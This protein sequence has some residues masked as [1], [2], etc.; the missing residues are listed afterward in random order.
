MK[1]EM[2]KGGDNAFEDNKEGWSKA[3]KKGRMGWFE[4]E[5]VG[6]D[7]FCF[8]LF[9]FVFD[10]F[11]FVLFCF[12]L[13]GF[14][15]NS[16]FLCF[17]FISFQLL[18]DSYI[19]ISYD[20]HDGNLIGFNTR[21][22]LCFLCVSPILLSSAFHFPRSVYFINKAEKRSLMIYFSMMYYRKVYDDEM[23]WQ[24]AKLTVAFIFCFEQNQTK[25]TQNKTKP[26]KTKQNTNK[27]KQQ[28]QNKNKT[29]NKTKQNKSKQNKNKTKHTNI[30]KQQQTTT[31]RIGTFN[32]LLS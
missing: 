18:S 24:R 1:E 20:F 7:L 3:K 14:V 19:L 29:Q 17:F 4:I 25:Q 30:N 23:Q 27:T 12:V 10:L 21:F 28:T 13:F 5:G 31:N 6:F 32:A 11:C 8:V 15:F 16:N 26:N 9:C 22:F 2:G